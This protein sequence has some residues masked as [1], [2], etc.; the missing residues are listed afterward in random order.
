MKIENEFVDYNTA[1]ALKKLGFNES[2]ILLYR[3]LDTQPVC[4]MSYD[5]KTEKN[6]DYNGAIN[7]WLTVPTFSQCFSWFREKYNIDSEFYMNHEYGI[8]FY[9]YLLFT[10]DSFINNYILSKHTKNLCNKYTNLLPVFFKSS[11]TQ[12]IDEPIE[13]QLN[14]YTIY[15]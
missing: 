5:F 4:Q 9:T 6:S 7:Y 13:Q 15:T 10:P 14:I 8:K 1:L 2:C 11:A 12:K 3:G